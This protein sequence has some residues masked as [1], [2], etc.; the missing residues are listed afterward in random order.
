MTTPDGF[1]WLPITTPDAFREEISRPH[2]VSEV[3]RGGDRRFLMRVIER[4]EADRQ[5]STNR[6]A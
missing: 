5:T 4:E 1:L 2:G 3:V 6:A